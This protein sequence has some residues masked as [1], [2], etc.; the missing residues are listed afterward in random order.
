MVTPLP[1]RHEHVAGRQI[2]RLEE[3]ELHS[4]GT[5][6]E[7][8]DVIDG[9][10]EHAFVEQSLR[11]EEIVRTRRDLPEKMSTDHLGRIEPGQPRLPCII[12][13]DLMVFI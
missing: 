2:R 7:R 11:H 13:N 12:G 5:H 6:P 8:E 10:V 1:S 3:P 9:R 4:G